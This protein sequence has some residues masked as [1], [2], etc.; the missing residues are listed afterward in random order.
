MK[1]VAGVAE[2]RQFAL[3]PVET[4]D[5]ALAGA[6]DTRFERVVDRARV[7]RGRHT[8]P[9]APLEVEI[10]ENLAADLDLDVGDQLEFVSFTPQQLA[11]PNIGN[12]EFNPAGPA[13]ALD[14][15]GIVRRPLD[16]GSRGAAGGVVVPTPAFVRD[17]RDRIGSYGGSILRVRLDA[18]RA[19]CRGWWPRHAGSS[20]SRRRS[21]SRSR[22]R[23][24]ATRSTSSPSPCGRS[25]GSRHWQ[26]W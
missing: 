24:L 21:R 26:A 20:V 4:S 16:L 11:D 5:L 6:V 25:P 10:G 7:V 9:S 19:I 17:Y 18:A 23:A 12:E 22:P 8:D 2:L 14:V 15:V 1:G 3:I 13:V